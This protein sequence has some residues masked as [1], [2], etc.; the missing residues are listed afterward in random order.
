M[1]VEVLEHRF[2]IDELDRMSEAGIFTEDDRAE[3]IDGEVVQMAPTGPRHASGV[4][5][6]IAIWPP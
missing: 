6:L 1:T 4:R 3:L 2:T 5:R